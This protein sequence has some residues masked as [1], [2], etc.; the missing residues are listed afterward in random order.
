MNQDKE[1]KERRTAVNQGPLFETTV[2]AS[3]MDCTGLTPTPPDSQAEAEAYETLYD[4]DLAG[5]REK[6]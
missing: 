3:S 1:K 5:G 6:K 2:T 4:I